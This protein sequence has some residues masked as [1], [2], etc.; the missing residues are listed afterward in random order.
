[1]YKLSFLAIC[2]LVLGFAMAASAADKRVPGGT[3]TGY[4]VAIEKNANGTGTITIQSAGRAKKGEA[5]VAGP[6]RKFTYNKSTKVERVK[7]TKQ[8]PRPA[9]ISDLVKD[10]LVY[11]T[12][13]GEVAQTIQV[14]ERMKK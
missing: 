13:K 4:I 7:G 6:E 1:M 12:A 5:A 11:I 10:L 3:V 14:E 8:P 2:G 9:E